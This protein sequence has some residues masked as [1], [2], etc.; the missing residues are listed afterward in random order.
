MVSIIRPA[1]RSEIPRND[2]MAWSRSDRVPVAVGFNPRV[3]VEPL[4]RG[5]QR[6]VNSAR[7]ACGGPINCRYATSRG[8]MPSRIRALKRPATIQRRYATNHVQIL[9]LLN[10]I[11]ND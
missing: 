10:R 8:E 2:D 1:I 11:R 9:D 7:C 5:A 4:V 6:R 3:G